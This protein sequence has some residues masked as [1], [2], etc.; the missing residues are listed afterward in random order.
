MNTDRVAAGPRADFCRREG[1]EFHCT[2]MTRTRMFK[3]W[4]VAFNRYRLDRFC[5]LSSILYCTKG[6]PGFT[7]TD[8]AP[9]GE[10]SR[11]FRFPC[12]LGES[13]FHLQFYEPECGVSY[14][15]VWGK[16]QIL[17]QRRL[18]DLLNRQRHKRRILRS[19]TFDQVISTNQ[20]TGCVVRADHSQ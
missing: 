10:P 19:E 6:Y 8:N 9:Y 18:N 5:K 2:T 3:Q 14:G 12:R 13:Y 17:A 20:Q 4:W 16:R 1:S 11:R 15:L 7:L